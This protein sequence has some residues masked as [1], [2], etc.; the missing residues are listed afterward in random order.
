M[1][2]ALFPILVSLSLLLK[3]GAAPL[4]LWFIR[5]IKTLDW[6]T[7]VLM[8]TVQKAIPLYLLFLFQL[9]RALKLGAGFR[10][11]ASLSVGRVKFLKKVMAL[12]SVFRLAWLL[13]GGLG[14]SSL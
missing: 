7:F 12:S 6:K 4:H 10:C 14:T 11:L 1:E 3:V 8:S 2:T 13:V 5:I 9:R